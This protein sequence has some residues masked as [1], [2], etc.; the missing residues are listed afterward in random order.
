GDV[1]PESKYPESEKLLRG[2]DWRDEERPRSVEDL[3][4]DDP[5]LVLPDIKGLDDY[6]P[7]EDFFDEDMLGRI[8]LAGKFHHQFTT[9]P[10][11]RKILSNNEH[12]KL[13]QVII[14]VRIE[15][16]DN[17]QL[18]YTNNLSTSF[19]A[20]QVISKNIVGKKEFQNI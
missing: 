20:T 6:I 19:S 2:F 17:F 3:F 12:T 11:Q 16:D 9:E 8:E 7:Q 1:Y 15:K 5:P 4:K 10:I 13:F 18:F 14:R